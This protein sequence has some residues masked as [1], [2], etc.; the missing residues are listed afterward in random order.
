MKHKDYYND[1]YILDLSHKI[2]SV[3]PDFDEKTFSYSLIGNLNDKEL[4]ARFDRIVDAMQKCMADDYSKNI[5]AFFNILG[6]ELEQARHR[7]GSLN[8]G[9]E[10]KS[11]KG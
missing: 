6:P 1:D 7:H 4:F 11:K 5:E 10:I 8:M 9:E 2:L 3:M